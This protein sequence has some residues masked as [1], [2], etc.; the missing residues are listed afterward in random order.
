MFFFV[1]SVSIALTA[2]LFTYLNNHLNIIKSVYGPCVYDD[3]EEYRQKHPL[4]IK[5]HPYK[6]DKELVDKFVCKYLDNLEN[7]S[8]FEED[9]QT[10]TEMCFTILKHLSDTGVDGRNIWKLVHSSKMGNDITLDEYKEEIDH[11]ILT[12]SDLI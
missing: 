11:Q 2:V 8:T 1:Y 4:H 9:V 12:Q 10:L 6:I 5:P 3:I 7:S